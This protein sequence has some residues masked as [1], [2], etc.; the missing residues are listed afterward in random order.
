VEKLDRGRMETRGIAQLRESDE[1]TSD[2]R[3]RIQAF[4]RI[5]PNTKAL[6]DTVQLLGWQ[7]R[8]IDSSL[9][10]PSVLK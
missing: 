2:L 1:R 8:S 6:N 7:A 9:W 3:R 10:D 4:G 5:D